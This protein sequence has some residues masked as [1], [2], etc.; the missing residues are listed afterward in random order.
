MYIRGL[1]HRSYICEEAAAAT[2]EMFLLAW[3]LPEVNLATWWTRDF[4]FAINVLLCNPF[5]VNGDSLNTS[6][7]HK[8]P[9]TLHIDSC[10]R[11]GNTHR[12]LSGD[13]L[14]RVIGLW[15]SIMMLRHA[16]MF[17]A[18]SD[19]RWAAQ[20]STESYSGAPVPAC[21][22]CKPAPPPEKTLSH[23]RYCCFWIVG[24]DLIRASIK[25]PRESSSYFCFYLLNRI[26]HT[27]SCR[28]TN[29]YAESRCRCRRL[30]AQFSLERCCTW[31]PGPLRESAPVGTAAN[32][33]SHVRTRISSEEDLLVCLWPLH[34]Y[35]TA[36][37]APKRCQNCKIWGAVVVDFSLYGS[38][39]V[40]QVASE[41]QTISKMLLDMHEKAGVV[42]L[43]F[44]FS[45]FFDTSYRIV[46]PFD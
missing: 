11:H 18:T 24:E 33:D 30:S 10:D 7:L 2:L 19:A 32:G 28:A 9:Q 4:H 29:S 35:V 37:F 44:L 36:V 41:G 40:P 13:F 43:N 31:V 20:G 3:D 46:F 21:Q 12:C 42:M 22:A 23:S 27:A 14:I 38:S 1:T 34:L 25:Q 39:A 6:S 5:G 16:G 26:Q 8:E 45:P 17:W 15:A